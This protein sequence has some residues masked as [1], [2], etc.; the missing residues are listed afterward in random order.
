MST[1]GIQFGGLASGLD[2][3]AIISALVAIERRPI[4][5]LQQKKTTLGKQKSLYGDLRGLLDK[6]ET[7]AR[8]LR[9]TTDFLQ[10]K[11]SS[12]AEGVLTASAG[13][14]ATPGSYRVRVDALARA[15]VNSSSG[16]AEPT[17]DLGGPASL[18]I[19]V[20]GETHLI[21]VDDPNLQ[22]IA[23]AINA[24]DDANDLGVRA[25]VVDTGNTANGGADR[26]QLVVRATATGVDGAFTIAYDDGDAAFQALMDDVG[27]NV[28]TAAS[29]AQLT[30]DGAIAIQRSSNQISDLFGGI[31][32][33]LKS[34]PVPATEVTITVTPDAEATAKKVQDFVDAYNKVVDFV[35]EQNALDAEG[36]AK[37]PLFGDS[38]LRSLR[39]SLRSIVGSEVAG[40]GNPA[41]QLFSQLGIKSDTA[42]KLTFERSKF[43]QALAA[44]EQAVAAVFTQSTGGIA[45]R[46]LGQIDSYTDS[47]E[48]LLKTRTD[49]YDRQVKDTQTRIDQAER[50]LS[51]FETQLEAKY[52]NLESLLSR[53]QSQ[54]SSLGAI[55]R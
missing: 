41:Y 28:R 18:Q 12:D 45:V 35:V 52:A 26:W 5:A 8:A 37:G 14:G 17:T 25:D 38:T 34:A 53:L 39:S 51:L 44:D 11:A 43:E 13:A 2:T 30:I 54:G 49:T 22:S 27:G 19:D 55:F 48:G 32:L 3:Q 23:A 31:T 40:T 33:D 4:Q 1:A 29:N 7:T 46:L 15:Q 9:T 47:V 50:R 6:L 16:S 20:G 42:G 10:M 21:T 24:Y 36:K